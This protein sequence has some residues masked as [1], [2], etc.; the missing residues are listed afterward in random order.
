MTTGFICH[1]GAGSPYTVALEAMHHSS[2]DSSYLCQVT[3]AIS[4]LSQSSLKSLV[5]PIYC[6]SSDVSSYL[7]LPPMLFVNLLK[8]TL[9]CSNEQDVPLA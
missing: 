6:Y 3:S 9:I 1:W 8:I 4:A 5:T 7:L 2:D